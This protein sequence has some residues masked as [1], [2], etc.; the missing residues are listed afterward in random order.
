MEDHDQ[1]GGR[2][3]LQFERPIL[4]EEFEGAGSR[5]ERVRQATARFMEETEKAIRG[6]PAAWL[7]IHDRW[8][9]RPGNESKVQSPKSKV[10]NTR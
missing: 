5:E 9:T 10:E 1:I 7:W 2:Y 4:A 6:N 8:K 3:R